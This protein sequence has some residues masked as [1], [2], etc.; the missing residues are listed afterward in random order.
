MTICGG[1]RDAPRNT[2]PRTSF[3]RDAGPSI[4][5]A[6]SPAVVSRVR[7][8][9][10]QRDLTILL[11]LNGLLIANYLAYLLLGEQDWREAP[12]LGVVFG[13]HVPIAIVS[14]VFIGRAARRLRRRKQG[15]CVRCGYDIRGNADR[16]SECGLP[17]G[18]R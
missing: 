18:A 5:A 11:S 14:L 2:I 3:R 8:P 12:Q 1:Q 13:V 7:L 16:C 17:I 6:G 15:L 4:A 10:V 9:G